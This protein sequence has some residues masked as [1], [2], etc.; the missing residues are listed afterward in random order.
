MGLLSNIIA[1]GVATAARNSTIKAV[2]EVAT[3]VIYAKAKNSTEKE[4]VVVKNGI[5]LI[6]PTRTS[7][8][9]YGENT[10]DIVKELFG[11]GFE[12]VTLKPVNKL[13][14]RAKA[15]YGKLESISI[16]GKEDF[17]GVKKVPSTAYIIIEYADFKSSTNPYVYKYVQKI[18]P[19]TIYR[20][21]FQDTN[22]KDENETTN[23]S[24][25]FCQ[26]CGNQ[27]D[28]GASFCSYCGEKIQ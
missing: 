26:Y 20:N 2:G 19:G 28:K 10:L 14:E 25:K 11:A 21:G 18:T 16:N 24:K 22:P 13:S 12:S 1:K 6:K 23:T 17:L 3:D 9:Y 4:D 8:D 7:E 27:L 5:T 15:K